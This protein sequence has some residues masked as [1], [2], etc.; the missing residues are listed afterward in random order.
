MEDNAVEP[1]DI[2][3]F[4]SKSDDL[5]SVL[6]DKKVDT[7]QSRLDVSTKTVNLVYTEAGI[8]ERLLGKEIL[9]PWQKWLDSLKVES[10]IKLYKCKT[11]TL[12]INDYLIMQIHCWQT[13]MTLVHLIHSSSELTLESWL[14]QRWSFMQ[15]EDWASWHGLRD[16][17]GGSRRPVRRA[18]EPSPPPSR[19]SWGSTTKWSGEGRI[20]E[21]SNSLNV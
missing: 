16:L 6:E 14:L 4:I 2:L 10:Q 8:I 13:D 3:I 17:G 1:C 19:S 15:K 9:R 7:Q 18:R 12:L 20:I 11:R 21:L 5:I